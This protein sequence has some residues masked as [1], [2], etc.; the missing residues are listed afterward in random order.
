MKNPQ[1]PLYLYNTQSR[2]KEVFTPAFDNYV[3]MYTC[4]P[5][6]YHYAHIGNFRTYIFE[7][8]LRRT[9]KFFGMEVTQ[10]MNITDIDD[11]TIRGAIQTG[12][13][14]SAFTQP[15]KTAFFDDIHTLGI[16]PVE[17]YPQATD[18]I[19]QMVDFIQHLLD[20]EVA[21]R[22]HDKSIYFSIEKFPTYGSLSHL[23]LGELKVGA[24]DAR[25]AYD[26]YEKENV[27]DFVLWKAYDPERDGNVYWD[28]PLGKGRPGWHLECSA[29]STALLGNT[30]DIHAGGVDNIFPHHENEIA[31]SEALTGK[32]F[33]RYWLHAEHLL[34]NHKKM[35][36]S[37]GNFYTLRDLLDKGF[38]GKEVRYMLM[39]THYRTQLNFTFEG[40]EGARQSLSRLTDFSL[41]MQEIAGKSPSSSECHS[42]LEKALFDFTKAMGDDLN[43]SVA[44]AAV[45][46]MMKEV[47]ILYDK[48]GLSSGDASEVLNVLQQ[49][50]GILGIFSFDH[51]EAPVQLKELLR[52]RIEARDQKN[53][54][55]ADMLRDEIHAQGYRIDDTPRGPRL[56]KEA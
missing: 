9:L 17:H 5:T 20:K 49:F 30:L 50:N 4:G 7:D 41:R 6:V 16:E 22:S 13:T 56:K 2:E 8:L 23:H 33:V 44:L 45:F 36:K 55:L 40:L 32:K 15:Y 47:N 1:L 42:I 14:L 21:Y 10:V 37:L 34:V 52:K 24:G 25:V 43:I 46:E 19:P 18:F 27:G 11:K 29:M 48:G 35:S 51:E 12:L 53:W 54:K 26:E 3:K 38:T 28:T 31:Q 39:Q